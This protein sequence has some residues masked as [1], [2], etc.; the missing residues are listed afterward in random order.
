MTIARDISAPLACILAVC[1]GLFAAASAQAQ[2]TRDGTEAQSQQDIN[3]AAAR[4]YTSADLALNDAWKSAKSFADAIG[5]GEALLTAQRAW[6]AYRDAA[7]EVQVSPFTGGSMR[8][9][10]L[11]ACLTTLTEERT[12]MLL[13]F[14]G[15]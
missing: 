12:R 3:A 5:Q 10:A 1:A 6:L 2:A 14:H 9:M 13:E 8:P 15:Y 7:C 4:D 11:S